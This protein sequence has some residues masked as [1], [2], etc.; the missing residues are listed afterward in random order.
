MPRPNPPSE[1]PVLPGERIAVV[2]E[3]YP[4]PWT[5]EEDGNIYSTVTGLAS[6]D[7]R[8]RMIFVKPLTRTPVVVEAGDVVIG[9]V[10]GVQEKMAIVSIIEVNGVRLSNPFT[11]ALNIAESSTRYERSMMDV[12]RIGDFVKAKV[13]NAKN[14][15]PIL[16]TIG[17]AFGVVKAFCSKCGHEL[18]A[19]GGSLHCPN[20]GNREV[21]KISSDYGMMRRG[22]G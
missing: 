16:S 4:G 11:G 20:C 12:C 7:Q 17:R 9:K 14:R 6:I 2:E 3:F 10:T 19:R 1:R 8:R 22:A 21:R 18:I 15:L 13:I 5:I